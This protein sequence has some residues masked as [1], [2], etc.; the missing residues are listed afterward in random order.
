MRKIIFALIFISFVGCIN[1]SKPLKEDKTPDQTA[2]AIYH[3]ESK[4]DILNFMKEQ[5][6]N[7]TIEE[8]GNLIGFKLNGIIW[9]N[10]KWDMV[11]IEFDNNDKA[12]ALSLMR[13]LEFDEIEYENIVK[14]L[15]LLYGPAT[16]DSDAIWN[17]RG[18]D[19][20]TVFFAK[21]RPLI[22]VNWK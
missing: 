20:T 2:W 12:T 16:H 1:T 7:V 17:F 13:G 5:Q 6:I 18:N 10:N 11:N 8:N 4:D 22:H 19:S 14:Y 3:G 15:E 21:Y 9:M